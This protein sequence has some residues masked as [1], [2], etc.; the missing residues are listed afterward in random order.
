MNHSLVKA[1]IGAALLTAAPLALAQ[2][3]DWML[4]QEV[5]RTIAS[6][7]TPAPTHQETY[8]VLPKGASWMVDLDSHYLAGPSQ[9]FS[10]VPSDYFGVL[11][12][13]PHWMVDYRCN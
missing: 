6:A 11:R 8:G 2:S 5:L 4:N 12:E 3:N 10:Y 13:G 7:A 9:Q 1:C